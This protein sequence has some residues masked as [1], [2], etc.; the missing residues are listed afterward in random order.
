MSVKPIVFLYFNCVLC[1]VQYGL[2]VNLQRGRF[3]KGNGDMPSSVNGAHLGMIDMFALENR[4]EDPECLNFPEL[5]ITTS[6]TS[7]FGFKR[8]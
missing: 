8:S 6:V 1:H 3:I 5:C 7:P 4:R 2:A